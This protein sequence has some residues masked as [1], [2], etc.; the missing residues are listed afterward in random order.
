MDPSY[1]GE[2]LNP[3]QNCGVGIVDAVKMS[4]FCMGNHLSRV[5]LK[6]DL[7]TAQLHQLDITVTVTT[8]SNN[9]QTHVRA[10]VSYAPLRLKNQVIREGDSVFIEAE[11]TMLG[12]FPCAQLR[13]LEVR[14]SGAG[15]SPP[16]LPRQAHIHNRNSAVSRVMD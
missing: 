1:E 10:D 8:S 3:S 13:A 14:K 6:R 15:Y 11:F 16:Q 12:N 2:I 9:V 7:H 5:N 4:Y